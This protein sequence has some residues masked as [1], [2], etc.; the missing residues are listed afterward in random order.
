MQSHF[1]GSRVFFG[2]Q[3][4]LAEADPKLPTDVGAFH[5][6]N[7]AAGADDD[8]ESR[9]QAGTKG[10]VGGSDHSLCPISRHGAA[11]LFGDRQSQTVDELLFG[12][13]LPQPTRGKVLQHVD[14]HVLPDEAFSVFVRLS[15]QMILSNCDVFH[16]LFRLSAKKS[17]TPMRG[18]QDLLSRSSAVFIFR[19][20]TRLIGQSFSALSA[21]SLQNVSAIGSSH[22]LSEAVLFFSLTLFRLIG[23][24]HLLA[25]P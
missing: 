11:D 13:F 2:H 6:H 23:S 3:S 10:V 17:K 19:I 18:K 14:R 8:E 15:I 22:S 7:G 12:I 21:S 5:V 9:T 1:I 4:E 20:W 24:E 16:F 25:P